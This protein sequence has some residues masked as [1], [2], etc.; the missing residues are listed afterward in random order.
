[1]AKIRVLVADDHAVLRAGLRLL[2]N[3]QRDLEVIG[4]TGDFMATRDAVGQ[5]DPDVATIDLSM[6]GGHGIRL[7]EW[8]SREA[9]RTRLL[10]LSMHDDP[11][12]VR[13][14]FAAGAAGYVM[15]KSADTDLLEAIRTVAVGRSYLP[16]MN[17]EGPVHAPRSAPQHAVAGNAA[18]LA[19]NFAANPAAGTTAA[20]ATVPAPTPMSAGVIVANAVIVTDGVNV[21]NGVIVAIHGLNAGDCEKFVHGV[22]RE[23]TPGLVAGG[24]W[25]YQPGDRQSVVFERQDDRVVPGA[26]DEQTGFEEPCLSCV[27]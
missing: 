10:V 13:M 20:D 17:E 19:A 7:V 23:G 1:M 3:T 22:E 5:L 14:A 25:I 4:E 16:R 12:Y 6:P 27:G 8:L 9:P 18:N 15:K 21:A 11:A 2:I 26:A 24:A